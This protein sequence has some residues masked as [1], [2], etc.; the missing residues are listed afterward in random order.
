MDYFTYIRGMEY[1]MPNNTP[2]NFQP[3]GYNLNAN[4]DMA[5]PLTFQDKSVQFNL[6]KLITIVKESVADE[7][8]DEMEY[9]MMAKL[10]PNDEQRD[11]I[12]SIR[13]N[14]KIHNKIFR[15]IFTEL[16]GVVLQDNNNEIKMDE[17]KNKNYID[18]LKEALMGELK[19]VERYREMLA[20]SPNKNIYNM[21]MYVLTDE[22]RHAIKYQYLLYLNK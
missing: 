19:A 17:N 11:I 15:K 21:I 7:Q 16:T 9:N 6:N 5:W 13:D 4:T 18:L 8:K 12:Y 3:F 22:I 14:E 10:A 20:Y 1:G 2:Y